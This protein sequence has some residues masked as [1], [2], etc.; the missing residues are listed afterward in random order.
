MLDS[1]ILKYSLKYSAFHQEYSLFV[2]RSYLTFSIFHIIL[3]HFSY[4]LSNAEPLAHM[5]ECEKQ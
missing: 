5:T 3:L 4:N 1:K 2:S